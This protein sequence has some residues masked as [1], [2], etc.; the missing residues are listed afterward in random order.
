MSDQEQA[1]KRGHSRLLVRAQS[2]TISEG[3][4]VVILHLYAHVL[5]KGSRLSVVAFQSVTCNRNT[6]RI[7]HPPGRGSP[8]KRHCTVN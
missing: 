6:P 1:R 7:F 4:A 2:G 5:S 3:N 8:V